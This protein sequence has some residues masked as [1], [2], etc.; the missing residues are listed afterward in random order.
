MLDSPSIYLG[1]TSPHAPNTTSMRGAVYISSSLRRW[2]ATGTVVTAGLMLTQLIQGIAA[3]KLRYIDLL[4]LAPWTVQ[5]SEAGG[6]PIGPASVPIRICNPVSY[7]AQKVL[8]LPS[9]R[10]EKRGKDV[11]DIYDTLLLVWWRA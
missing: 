7:L 11:L 2:Q 8:S 3:E 1:T 4:L 10:R 6:Y 9:R 5:L